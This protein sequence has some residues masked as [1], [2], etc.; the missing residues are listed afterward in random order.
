MQANLVAKFPFWERLNC[1]LPTPVFSQVFILKK[2]EFSCTFVSVDSA[3]FS[4]TVQGAWNWLTIWRQHGRVAKWTQR[5]P[6]WPVTESISFF[7]S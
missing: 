7:E 2:V 5:I 1:S 4:L 6:T 3:G